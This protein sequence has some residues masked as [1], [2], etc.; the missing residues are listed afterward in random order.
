MR[1]QIT[2]KRLVVLDYGVRHNLVVGGQ[3]E[4]YIAEITRRRPGTPA[5]ENDQTTQCRPDY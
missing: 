1:Q 4:R 5:R 3:R 2:R